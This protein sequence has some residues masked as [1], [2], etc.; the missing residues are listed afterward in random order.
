M[1]RKNPSPPLII[2][3]SPDIIHLPSGGRGGGHNISRF[4]YHRI[5]NNIKKIDENRAQISQNFLGA[6]G[7]ESEKQG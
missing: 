2:G 7:A 5:F 6:I 1:K 3:C 4:F